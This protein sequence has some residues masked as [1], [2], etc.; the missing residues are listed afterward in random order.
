[1]TTEKYLPAKHLASAIF[2]ATEIRVSER[3]VRDMLKAG[4]PRLGQSARLSD[5]M[6]WWGK[7][8]DFSPRSKRPFCKVG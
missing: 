5:L 3:F 2:E 1:M 8:P 4:V 6:A 7:H